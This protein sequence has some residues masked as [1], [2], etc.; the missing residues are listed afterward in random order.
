MPIYEHPILDHAAKVKTAINARDAKTLNMVIRR[1]ARAYE[2]LKSQIAYTIKKAEEL[3]ELLTI[4]QLKG[5]QAYRSLLSGVQKEMSIF[6]DDLAGVLDASTMAEID[7]ALLDTLGMTQSAL[8]GMD[9]AT[10]KA[11]WAHLSPEQTRTM[12]AFLDENGPLY[13]GILGQYGDAVAKLASDV[14][15]TG[16]ITGQN[17]ITIARHMS[18]VAG[19]ALEWSLTTVRTAN[20]WAYRSASQ[21]NYIQNAAIV[22]GWMWY[23]QLDISTC[24]S[25]VFQHG[26]IHSIYE[27][28]ADHHRGRCAP[29]PITKTYAELGF[30]GIKDP[31]DPTKVQS[32]QAWYEGLS[33]EQQISM[34]GQA[35]HK[36]WQA[37]AFEFDQL[38]GVYNDPIYGV[39]RSEPS[40]VKILGPEAEVYYT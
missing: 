2:K 1:Y 25:C 24:L 27:I 22:K 37:G 9:K 7:A 32:G 19:T 17:P 34:M 33:T 15:S 10:L 3:G 31:F 26:S 23:A 8:P 35:K 28:L 11:M 40:L 12:I 4:D 39:M 30:T 21:I 14:M 18:K 20:L 38:S 29:L 16:F 5:L 13:K 6:A 36:A